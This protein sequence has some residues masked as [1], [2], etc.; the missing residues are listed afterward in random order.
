MRNEHC[1]SKATFVKKVRAYCPIGRQEY[2]A[3]I[4]CSV[5]CGDTI[6]DYL[7]LDAAIEGIDGDMLTVE[8]LARRVHDM[9]MKAFGGAP[10]DTVVSVG[11]SKHFP[12]TVEVR[13]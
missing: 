4:E 12:V 2:E 8:A 7:Q 10:V 1:V 5:K 13:D 3:N 6:P 9:T 11:Q